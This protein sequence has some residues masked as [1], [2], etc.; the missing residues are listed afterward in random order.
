MTTT[1]TATYRTT[2]TNGTVAD[3]Q[4]AGTAPHGWLGLL[5]AR[6]TLGSRS[7]RDLVGRRRAPEAAHRL[8]PD[9]P[10]MRF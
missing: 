3:P 9:V 10:S 4:P 5:R 8:T 7:G 1:T 2:S 6:L